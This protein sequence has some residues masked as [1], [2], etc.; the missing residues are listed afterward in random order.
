MITDILFDFSE[1]FEIHV[2][3]LFIT[4]VRGDLVL[5]NEPWE[6]HKQRAPLI[7]VSWNE[8]GY[9]YR[10]RDDVSADKRQKI[11]QHLED[12]QSFD[13][14]KQLPCADQIETLLSTQCSESG[15]TYLA[16]NT[17]QP[18]GEAI[19]VE[20][21]NV[22][23]LRTHFESMIDH[24]EDFQPCCVVLDGSDAVSICDTVRRSARAVEAGLHTIETHQRKGY[25]VAVTSAWVKAVKVEGLI[26]IYSTS[27]ENIAS[28]GV[29]KKVG[30]AP[31]A[32]E[33][34]AR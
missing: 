18:H 32:V 31:F 4:N 9:A 19:L 28:Q 6:K 33:Y 3:T 8:S 7:Y 5:I 24:I 20:H 1:F 34:S 10:F 12:V 29:A 23:V 17:V 27:W 15:P 11:E 25:A 16:P 14:A 30:L 13:G 26:P 22:E 2:D 21:D